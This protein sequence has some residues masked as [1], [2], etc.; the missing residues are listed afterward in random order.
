MSY[1]AKWRRRSTAVPGGAGS[2]PSSATAVYQMQGPTREAMR[3]IGLDVDEGADIVMVK[4]ALPCLTYRRA[5]QEFGS[6]LCRVSGERGV[7]DIKA[8]GSRG[9]FDEAAPL[10]RR[11]R[12]TAG[13]GR[14][15][16]QLFRPTSR[17]PLAARQ[18]HH[19]PQRR[20]TPAPITGPIQYTAWR[21][22]HATSAGPI[23]RAGFITAPVK[24]PPTSASTKIA[25]P[26]PK[27]RSWAPPMRRRSRTRH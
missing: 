23:A 15:P 19:P 8:G 6:P 12:D 20:G 14:H 21:H 4:P 7:R 2:T 27:R 9:M 11:C 3:E 5:K 13:R 16:P 24:L 1:A 17:R 26:M 10:W 22:C 25:R 18:Q